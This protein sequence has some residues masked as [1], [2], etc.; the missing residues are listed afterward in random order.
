MEEF[1]VSRERRGGKWGTGLVTSSL[2]RAPR[3]GRLRTRRRG[4]VSAGLGL[5]PGPCWAQGRRQNKGS[6]GNKAFM[7]K[8]CVMTI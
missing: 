6:G 7:G 3:P 4:E 1:H 5:S 2:A 8:Q